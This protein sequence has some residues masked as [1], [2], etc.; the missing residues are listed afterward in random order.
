MI[1]CNTTNNNMCVG[2]YLTHVMTIMMNIFAEVMYA[3]L[4]Q[5]TIY[6]IWY[7]QSYKHLDKKLYNDIID[8]LN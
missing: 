2:F 4:L 6:L 1:L 5:I 7:K 3:T 8:V